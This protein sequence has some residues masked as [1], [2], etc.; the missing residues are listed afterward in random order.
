MR[1]GILGGT[2][3]PIHFG[4]LAAAGAAMECGRLDRVLFIP[5]ARPPHR[6]GALAPASKRLE[7]CR[8]AVA[9]HTGFE[10]SDI[11]VRRGGRSYTSDTLAALKRAHPQDELW[12]ILGWDAA[13]LFATWHEPAKVKELASFVVVSRPG[14]PVPHRHELMAAG[15]DPAQV[16]LCLRVTPDISASELRHAIAS[17][18][19]IPQSV[20]EAVARYIAE[21]RL[22]RDNR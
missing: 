13:K 15:F 21:H 20:P 6:G 22:Y 10:A 14:T 11:E 9:G 3:D 18:E 1:I 7:M 19:S 16:E 12:L 5:S 8:L 4:H 17:G 2:F